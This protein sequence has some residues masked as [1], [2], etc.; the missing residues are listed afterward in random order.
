[1][2]RRAFRIRLRHPK[3]DRLSRATVY[4]DGKRVRTLRGRRLRA[5]VNLKGLPKGRF[6]VKVQAVT[7]KG[8]HVTDVRVYRTCVRKT[9]KG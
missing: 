7:H 8:R 4:V 6:T 3:G 5:L 1:V 2:S 9:V